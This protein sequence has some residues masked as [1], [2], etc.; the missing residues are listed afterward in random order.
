V[1][2]TVMCS[3]VPTGIAALA[4]KVPA[5]SKSYCAAMILPVPGGT[6]IF[7]VKVTG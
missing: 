6:S 1:V 2:F 7:A 4:G 3:P 5:P